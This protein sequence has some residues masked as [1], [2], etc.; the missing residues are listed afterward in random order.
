MTPGDKWI[1]ERLED[2]EVRA[3]QGMEVITEILDTN[4]NF[5]VGRRDL[6]DAI[7]HLARAHWLLQDVRNQRLLPE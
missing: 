1:I 5:R 4:P 3:E 2:A 6:V 7:A